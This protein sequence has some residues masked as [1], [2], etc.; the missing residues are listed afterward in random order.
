[1][2]IGQVAK[3]ADV[4]IDTVRYYERRGLL[5]EPERQRSSNYREYPA[6]TAQ[7]IRFIKR[8]QEL[9]FTLSQVE[10]LL[11]LRE[12]KAQSRAEVRTL[13]AAKL[14]DIDEKI[15]RLQSMRAALGVLLDSCA[16]GRGRP[17]CPILAALDD[18][19]PSAQVRIPPKEPKEKRN[20]KH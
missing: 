2:K 10:E 12:G 13:A 15:S 19:K 1:M 17:P 4:N 20:G 14:R 9:G 18:P 6:D 8:A 16:C 11:R 3:Q 5:D 7:L